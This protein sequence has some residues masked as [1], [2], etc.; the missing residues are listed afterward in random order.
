M[1]RDHVPALPPG[2][3]LLGA[4]DIS[5]VQGMVRFSP[6]T[7]RVHI[8]T[9]QGHPE[10]TEPIVT[11]IIAQR[12][13]SGAIGQETAAEYEASRRYVRDDGPGR[14]GRTLWKVITGDL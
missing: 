11:A 5:P 12:S 1:H 9:V 3:E 14:V 13:G 8:F 10:F 2:F 4:T 7:D 6:D